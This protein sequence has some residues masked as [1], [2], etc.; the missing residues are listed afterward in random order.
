MF[1]ELKSLPCMKQGAQIPRFDKSYNY[2]DQLHSFSVV[3]SQDLISKT[4]I[5]KLSSA[6]YFGAQVI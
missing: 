5:F 1:I 4:K 2:Y 6:L 3:E